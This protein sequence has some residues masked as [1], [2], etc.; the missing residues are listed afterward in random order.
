M[1]AIPEA[2]RVQVDKLDGSFCEEVAALPGGEHIRQ[3]FACGTCA[4]GCPVTDVN[5][6]YNPRTIIRQV[7]FGMREEVLS[8]PLLWSCLVCYRCYARCPQGVNFTDIMRVLRYLAVKNGHVPPETAS[9]IEE[10]DRVAQQLRVELVQE[11]VRGRREALDDLKT[12]L[13]TKA[14]AEK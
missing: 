12:R 8:S 3:C 4:A 9:R 1:T 11:A 13:G 10:L 7:L 6:E 14:T 2:E 5:P